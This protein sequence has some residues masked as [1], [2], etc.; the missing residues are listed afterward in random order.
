[1]NAPER[2][3]LVVDDEPYIVDLVRL[4]L[5]RE[6]FLV[7]EA[8]NGV[9]A[10]RKVRE[11]MPDLVVLDVMMPEMDGFEALKEIRAI[12]NTPVIMLTVQATEPD[13]VRGLELGADDYLAKPFS[14]REL[15]GRIKAVLRRTE[16]ANPASLRNVTQ[17]DDDLSVDWD[18]REVIVRGEP[19]RLRPTEYKLLYHL[20][21]NAGRLMP[22]DSLLT[23]VWGREYRDDTQLL[24]LY[25]TYLRQKI[26]PNPS[27]PRYILNERGLGYRFRELAQPGQRTP[28]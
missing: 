21:Q 2:R 26:E 10:V 3:I 20:V 4:A 7:D 17:I 27:S 24:R 12:S 18:K 13:R 28:P 11:L 19:V 16:G 14:H 25:V 23:R 22:H 5:E 15:L 8:S 1:L 9:E 6:Q